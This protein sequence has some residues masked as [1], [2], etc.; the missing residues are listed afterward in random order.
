M[1]LHSAFF[2]AQLSHTP[3]TTGKTIVLTTWTFV[4]KVMSL[5]S[6]MLPRL[7]RAFLPRSKHLLISWLQSLSAVIW[8][9]RKITSVT[10]TTVSPYIYHEKMEPD[11]II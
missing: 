8:E 5:L 4:S 11:A 2:I 9:P 6:N 1:L 10:I 7:V 3:M